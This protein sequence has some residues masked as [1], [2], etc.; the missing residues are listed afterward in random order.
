MPE[1]TYTNVHQLGDR[2]FADFQS[3]AVGGAWEPFVSHLADNATAVFYPAPPT[4]N[5]PQQGKLAIG[6]LLQRFTESG[7]RVQQYP[8]SPVV[9]ESTYS[10]EFKSIGTLNG[11]PREIDLRVVFEFEQGKI[12][13]VQEY[14]VSPITASSESNGDRYQPVQKPSD[15][16]DIKGLLAYFDDQCFNQKNYAV[17]EEIIDENFVSHDPLPGQ[18]GDKAGLY[19]TVRAFHEAF[20]DWHLHNE[21]FVVEGDTVAHRITWTGTHTK[22]FMGFKPTGRKIHVRSFDFNRFKHG[23]MVERWSVFDTHSFLKQLAGEE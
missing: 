7:L 10:V 1:A 20:P 18:P 22:E 3:W 12:V 14:G 2:A 4:F 6:Q 21:A 17:I 11:Q 9:S 16:N 23:K 8:K 5:E 15:P 13:S 19:A